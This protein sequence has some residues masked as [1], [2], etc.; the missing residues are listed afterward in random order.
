VEAPKMAM[1][2]R[3]MKRHPLIS[4]QWLQNLIFNVDLLKIIS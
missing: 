4:V 1:E 2:R 3:N